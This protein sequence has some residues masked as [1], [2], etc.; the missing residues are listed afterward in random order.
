[1]KL[2]TLHNLYVQELRDLHAAEIQIQ[3]ALP[4]VIEA[5]GSP[6]L[7]DALRSHLAITEGQIARLE[8]ILGTHGDTFPDSPCEGMRGLIAEVTA[9][10]DEEGDA[11]IRDIGLIAGCRRIEHYEMAG[12]ANVR[13]IA[14]CLGC[15]EDALM[16]TATLEEE[17]STDDELTSVVTILLSQCDTIY[18]SGIAEDGTED[19]EQGVSNRRNRAAAAVR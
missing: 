12:Y 11:T 9:L 4:T 1:M 3:A 14:E 17:S 5:A 10:M 8:N 16:L 18:R 7:K 19:A 2:N 13:K 6:D 15:E